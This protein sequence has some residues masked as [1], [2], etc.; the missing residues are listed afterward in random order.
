MEALFKEHIIHAMYNK[1]LMHAD[2]KVETPLRML[3]LAVC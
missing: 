2:W 1:M 3:T